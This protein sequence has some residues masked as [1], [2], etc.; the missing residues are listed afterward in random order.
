MLFKK[1]QLTDNPIGNTLTWVVLA[2]FLFSTACTTTRVIKA[3]IG[4]K[5][6]GQGQTAP[7]QQIL[8][9]DIARLHPAQGSGA[10]PA[11][12]P[13]YRLDPSISRV[14]LVLVVIAGVILWVECIADENCPNSL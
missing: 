9:N 1:N 4:Y 5:L 6:G 2:A 7:Q 14:I 13:R 12:T 8:V 10:G 3:P 11:F